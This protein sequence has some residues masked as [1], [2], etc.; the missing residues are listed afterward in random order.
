MIIKVVGELVC[1]YILHV[2]EEIRSPRRTAWTLGWSWGLATH[3]R[4]GLGGR[5]V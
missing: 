3:D 2:G 5:H 4:S 1:M